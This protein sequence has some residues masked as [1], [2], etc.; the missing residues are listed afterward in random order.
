[1]TAFVHALSLAVGASLNLVVTV[2][3]AV[4]A[5]VALIQLGL[6]LLRPA[7][8]GETITNA[9]QSLARWLVLGLEYAVAA[10]VV[11]MMVTPSWSELGMLAALVGLR[12]ALNYSLERELAASIPTPTAHTL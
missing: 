8:F 4:G 10:D 6:G 2:I 11:L 1:M 9:R 5:V 12:M 7:S 3:V